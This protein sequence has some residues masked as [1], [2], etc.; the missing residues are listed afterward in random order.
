MLLKEYQAW[1]E[2]FLEN[3][4][5][6]DGLT[7]AQVKRIKEKLDQAVA[8]ESLGQWTTTPFVAPDTTTTDPNWYPRTGDGTSLTAPLQPTDPRYYNGTVTYPNPG[9][10]YVHSGTL[11]E[12]ADVQAD[13]ET[14]NV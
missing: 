1:L 14:Q 7:P 4:C 6:H 8:E 2:G 9:D 11:E 3:M 10:G 12:L 5:E 13:T